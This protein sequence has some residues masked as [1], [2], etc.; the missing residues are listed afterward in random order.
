MAVRTFTK[1]SSLDQKLASL[2]VGNMPGELNGETRSSQAAQKTTQTYTDEQRSPLA[3]NANNKSR[4]GITFAAQ[5][6]LPQ[7]PIP[8]LESTCKKYVASLRPLQSS[9]E[10]RD[11]EVAIKEFLRTDGP[12]L[13]EKLKKYASGRSNYIEQFCTSSLELD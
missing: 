7:L 1:P 5:D 6:K 3:A 2:A 8:D 13:Q 4:P 11:T 10:H 9:K 12:E